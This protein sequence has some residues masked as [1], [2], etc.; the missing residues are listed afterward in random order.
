MRPKSHGHSAGGN[1]S[2]TYN[3]WATMQQRCNNHKATSY[4]RYGGRGIKVCERWATFS[5]FLADMGVRP[6]GKT[7][8]RRDN[9]G[10]YTSEN[11]RWS[12]LSVQALNQRPNKRG[13]KLN[14]IDVERVS[15]LRL[16]GKLLERELAVYFQVSR[17]TIHHILSKRTWC[18]P[19][20]LRSL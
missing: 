5:N 3:S 6:E 1:T 4:P 7:L 12:S 8:D 19:T 2:P 15:D 10:D 20:S 13:T 18:A 16:T 9:G 14:V 11:C 17:S